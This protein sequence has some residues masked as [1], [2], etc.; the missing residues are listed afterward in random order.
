MS[1]K[2]KYMGSG[3]HQTDMDSADYCD[4][5]RCEECDVEAQ[6]IQQPDYDERSYRRLDRDGDHLPSSWELDEQNVLSCPEE[7]ARQLLES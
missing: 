3:H 1:H 4:F 5:W 7:T 6:A 2:W